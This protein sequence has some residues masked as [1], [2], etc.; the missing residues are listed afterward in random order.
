MSTCCTLLMNAKA[1]RFK[2]TVK[3]EDMRK[4]LEKLELDIEVVGTQSER[5]MVETLK[6]LVA[7]KAKRVAVA[8]GDGTIHT[9]IQILAKTDTAL[10]IVPQGTANN[11]ATALRLPQDLPSALRTLQ[12]GEFRQVDLGHACGQY[13]VESAGVGLFANALA[14]YG[15]K[16]NKNLL[17]SLH[18]VF[19]IIVN[20]RASRLQITV[21]GERIVEPAVFAVAANTFRMAHGLP[22]APG[23]SVTDGKLDLMVLKDLTR[24]ELWPY[25]L[26]IRQQMHLTLD[27]AE[28]RQGREIK[29][30]TRRPVPVHVD[31]KVR[32]MTP[33]VITAEPRALRVIVE[34][35]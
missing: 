35:L 2:S 9:A 31:D 21:D 12:D 34:K 30:E 13:F 28:M 5:H 24:G 7:K 26:A 22:V 32:G 16:A 27:K 6:D 1:G 17:R 18:A 29:I 19:K 3:P 14:L 11:V 8:G 4:L 20:L 25:Y 33:V 15:A 23:A 10:G